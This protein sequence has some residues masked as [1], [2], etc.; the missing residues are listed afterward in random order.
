MYVCMRTN[1][2]PRIEIANADVFPS[3]GFFFCFSFFLFFSFSLLSSRER[4][5]RGNLLT[6][7]IYIHLWRGTAIPTERPVE[8]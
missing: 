6:T 2:K 3:F 7:Y 8:M 1:R 5:P 4:H